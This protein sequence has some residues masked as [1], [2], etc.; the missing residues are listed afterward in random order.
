MDP[1]ARLRLEEDMGRIKKLMGDNRP[2]AAER[3]ADDLVRRDSSPRSLSLAG[4]VKFFSGK[5]KQG[6]ALWLR[7]LSGEG[8]IRIQVAH[9][10]G[11][12]PRG[13][14]GALVI[15]KKMIQYDSVSKSQHNFVIMTGELVAASARGKQLMLSRRDRDGKIQRDW[16]LL[17]WSRDDHD[18]KQLSAFLS[19]WFEEE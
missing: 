13:C 16:F 12:V 4:N 7:A 5:Y 14:V 10:H 19:E 11:F 6:K 18:V 8:E 17:E 3:L 9:A 1:G 2:A 15:R